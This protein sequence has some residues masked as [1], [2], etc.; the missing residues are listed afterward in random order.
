MECIVDL[1]A[2]PMTHE[3]LVPDV[4]ARPH[5]ASLIG[6][7]D[8]RCHQDCAVALVSALLAGDVS[9]TG[10]S[11]L[12]SLF[13]LIDPLI[14]DERSESAGGAHGEACNDFD[15]VSFTAE[16]EKVARLVHHLRHSDPTEV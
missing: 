6:I 14:H 11:T 15:P 12:V 9:I 2:A 10:S 1:V 3:R 8:H 13:A 5:H 16:Q 4:L 7:F